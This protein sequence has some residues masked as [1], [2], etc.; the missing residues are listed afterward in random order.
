MHAA[1]QAY[2]N[3]GGVVMPKFVLTEEQQDL[4]DMVRRFLAEKS[5]VSEV[6]RLM[7]TEAGHDPASPS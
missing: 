2:R 4:R 7:A 6:R 3:A 1:Y 5:P